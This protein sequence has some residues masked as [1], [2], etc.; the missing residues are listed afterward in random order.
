MTENFYASL[1]S[2]EGLILRAAHIYIPK[3]CKMFLYHYDQ[4]DDHGS[5]CF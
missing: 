2:N 3:R 1:K 4:F 5:I